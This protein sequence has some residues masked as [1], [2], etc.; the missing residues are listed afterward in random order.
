MTTP[1]V[2]S[3]FKPAAQGFNVGSPQGVAMTEVAGGLPRV[4]LDW[5]RGW[6]PFQ[7]SRVMLDD[8]FS[9][10]GV[11][12]HRRINNGSIQFTMPINSGQGFVD[13]LCV[14]VPGSYSAVPLSGGKVWSV[15]FTVMAEN[16]VYEMSDED[17]DA[18]LEFWDELGPAGDDLLARIALFATVDTLVLMP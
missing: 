3:T 9:A 7:V 14:M 17:V 8:E 18:L 5:A 11:F 1:R 4:A 10:W 2:P 12:F 6:Q 13:H 15:A 16:P